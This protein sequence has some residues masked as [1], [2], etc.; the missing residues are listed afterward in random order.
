MKLWLTL[1]YSLTKYAIFKM[2][3]VCSVPRALEN[4]LSRGQK[5]SGAPVA[6]DIDGPLQPPEEQRMLAGEIQRLFA[7]RRRRR[8]CVWFGEWI[9][10]FSA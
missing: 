7:G 5:S 9:R 10:A 6:A 2:D 4:G 8:V 1:G 3:A